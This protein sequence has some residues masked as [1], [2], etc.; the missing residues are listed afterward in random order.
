MHYQLVIAH[1]VCPALSRKAVGFGSKLDLVRAG[2]MSMRAALDGIATKF[3]AI[4][5]GCPKEYDRLFENCFP[6]G[7]GI[8]LQIVR[9]PSIGNC[10]TYVRQ[11]E[12]LKEEPGETPV[13]LSE[14]DY[15]YAS[16]AFREML[17]FLKCAE[18]D[19]LTPLDHP[20]RYN[21]IDGQSVPRLIRACGSWHWMEVTS[22]CCTFLTTAGR[23]RR[24]ERLLMMYVKGC[25]D[26]AMWQLVTRRALWRLPF[27]AGVAVRM[28][29]HRP[30]RAALREQVL[31][32]KRHPLTVLFAP[33]FRLWGPIPTLA[34]HVCNNSLP[35]GSSAYFKGP[36]ADEV[37][38]LVQEHL[39]PYLG[40]QSEKGGNG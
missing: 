39:R 9:T 24:S 17:A 7:C 28:L 37:E 6:S 38:L 1:R 11:I 31:V 10:A 8:D 3:V 4:L 33:R 20:D 13:Y 29:L 22:T 5:D 35:S 30:V 27:L 2:V 36:A 25:T 12:I 15:L 21:N 40:F 19:F 34:V 23:L 18:V 26:F 14:D 32:W 16:G